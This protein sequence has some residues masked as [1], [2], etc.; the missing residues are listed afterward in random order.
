M[1]VVITLLYSAIGVL[2]FIFN[3]FLIPPLTKGNKYK[4]AVIWFILGPIV[5]VLLLTHYLITLSIKVFEPII[6]K[7]MNWILEKEKD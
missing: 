3:P 7:I 5:W 1:M 2:I 6:N 4:I